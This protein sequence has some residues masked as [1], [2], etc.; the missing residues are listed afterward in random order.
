[1]DAPEYLDLDEIDFT[2]D[3]A[4]SKSFVMQWENCA[5]YCIGGDYGIILTRVQ[6]FKQLVNSWA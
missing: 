4:V 3:L 6:S 2:D 5:D 1:M